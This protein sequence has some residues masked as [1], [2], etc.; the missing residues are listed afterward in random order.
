MTTIETHDNTGGTYMDEDF[1]GAF[2][3]RTNWDRRYWNAWA[4]TDQHAPTD[5]YPGVMDDFGNLVPVPSPRL[6]PQH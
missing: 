2:G 4:R 6:T 5:C 1:S 3:K